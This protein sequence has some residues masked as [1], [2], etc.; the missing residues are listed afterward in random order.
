MADERK[1]LEVQIMGIGDAVSEIQRLIKVVET[2]SVQQGKLDKTAA[3]DAKQYASLTAEL[4]MYRTQLNAVTKETA[5]AIR[6]TNEKAGYLEALEQDVRSLEQAYRRLSEAEF[7]GTQGKAILENLKKQRAALASAQADYGKYSMNVGNYA[8]ATNMLAIN[9]GQVMKEIPNFAISARIGIMSLTNN[10]PMLG[11]AIKAVRVQQQ[12][13]IAEGQKAPSMFSLISKSVFGL[14]GVLSIAMV[15]LQLYGARIIEWIGSLFKAKNAT[16]DLR[17]SLTELNKTSF[18]KLQSDMEKI[19]KFQ[20]DY[21]KA[22][23]ES[24]KERVSA[25]DE[26]ARKEFGIDQERLN[27]IKSGLE[28]WK[29]F[30]TEYLNIARDTYYNEAL[31]KM[32]TEKQVQTQLQAAEKELILQGIKQQLESAG[33]VASQVE[34]ITNRF[35][36]GQLDWMDISRMG[37]TN[38]TKQWNALQGEVK[39]T[40]EETK[41]LNKLSLKPIGGNY[42][43]T[44]DT[45]TP[46]QSKVGAAGEVIAPEGGSE[47]LIAR[48]TEYDENFGDYLRDLLVKAEQARMKMQEGSLKSLQESLS[49]DEWLGEKSV[50]N[51]LMLHRIKME[52]ERNFLSDMQEITTGNLFAE[53]LIK[54]QILDQQMK[55]ELAV[56]KLTEEQKTAIKIK[57]AKGTAEIVLGVAGEIDKMMTTFANAELETWAQV[58][59][60]KVGFV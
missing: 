33:Y 8:S 35:K 18:D 28:T 16:D 17:K 47:E 50:E 44:G 46:K 54:K 55:D 36:T 39:K 37:L 3:G 11:E 25:L 45:K 53:A 41:I 2:L 26:F 59:R 49:Y 60:G 12:A 31:I 19:A 48:L 13:M 38:L 1:V 42:I 32:K 43:S 58:N 40:T 5:Q 52:N 7:K 56:A 21:R 14:T 30:F 10:L 29:Q 27:R 22:I 24:N 34:K 9:V 15:F 4:K 6:V 51:Q 20:L 23:R 57:N